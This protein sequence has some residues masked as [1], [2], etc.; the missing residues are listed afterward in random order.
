MADGADKLVRLDR[1]Q[2]AVA[3]HKAGTKLGLVRFILVAKR[4]FGIGNAKQ[5][6]Y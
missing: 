5:R 4:F 1:S 2:R 6:T 3:R